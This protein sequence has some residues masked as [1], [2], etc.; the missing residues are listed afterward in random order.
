MLATLREPPPKGSLRE[1]V[2]LMY[3]LKRDQV[4]HGRL[5][6]LATAIINKEK[7][8]EAFDDYMKQAFPW[9]ESQKSRDHQ[10]NITLLKEEIK[11]NAG[12]FGI[13]PLWEAKNKIRS[14]LKTRV[15][16]GGIPRPKK[17]MDALY[18]KLG[19]TIPV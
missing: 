5:R 4:E 17:E 8:G 9:L 7:A 18:K 14:R 12:G 13:K 3:V 19:K 10:R 6:A 15:V 16:E 2:L 1:S 11:R